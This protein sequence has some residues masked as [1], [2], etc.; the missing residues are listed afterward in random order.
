MK[1][2]YLQA[3]W[4]LA[5]DSFISFRNCHWRRRERY[6]AAPLLDVVHGDQA[7]HVLEPVGQEVAGSG[8][9]EDGLAVGEAATR[10]A[11]VDLQDLDV[12]VLVVHVLHAHDAV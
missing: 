3:L 2:G 4:A 5:V 11:K 7:A 9:A 10:R 1:V 6:A 8:L 12:A